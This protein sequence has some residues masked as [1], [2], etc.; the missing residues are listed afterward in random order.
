MLA[1]TR[2]PTGLTPRQRDCLEAIRVHQEDRGAMPSIAEL[3][4]QMGIA[5]KSGV[6]RLLLQLET[7]GAI[8]RVAGR[9][10][11]IRIATSKCP[12]CGEVV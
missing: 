5:S 8:K 12:H 10:R 6:H 3:Q 4:S 11:A 2:G 7:R 1:K 9:A